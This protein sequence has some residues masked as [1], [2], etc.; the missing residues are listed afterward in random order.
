M[1]DNAGIESNGNAHT[2]I[3]RLFFLFK[4]FIYEV[5]WN[6]LIIRSMTTD[7]AGP[8]RVEGKRI[9]DSSK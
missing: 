7:F 4:I 9:V 8:S 5:P 1:A 6:Q 2:K 3:V